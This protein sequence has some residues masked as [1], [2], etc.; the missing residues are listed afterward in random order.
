MEERIWFPASGLAKPKSSIAPACRHVSS[1]WLIVV[2]MREVPSPPSQLIDSVA[3]PV[4]LEVDTEGNGRFSRAALTDEHRQGL[5]ATVSGT[6]I[7]GRDCSRHARFNWGQVGVA[8]WPRRAGRLIGA[9]SLNEIGAVPRLTGTPP[10]ASR[11]P[12]SRSPSTRG[13]HECD[14]CQSRADGARQSVV[15]RRCRGTR[16]DDRRRHRAR[17]SRASRCRPES[18]WSEGAP[19]PSFIPLKIQYHQIQIVVPASLAPSQCVDTPSAGHP[20]VNLGGIEHLEYPEHVLGPHGFL[21]HPGPRPTQQRWEWRRSDGTP[22]CSGNCPRQ[23]TGP[24]Q[25]RDVAQGRTHETPPAQAATRGELEH[26]LSS[27]L[28]QPGAPAGIVT[29][30]RREHCRFGQLR[31]S[32][33]HGISTGWAMDPFAG[34]VTLSW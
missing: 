6:T 30:R 31:Q 1:R 8:A 12:L 5:S 23:S 34:L 15:P 27:R 7:S 21:M 32:S 4:S 10:R 9:H 25:R 29:L 2:V 33:A 17:T 22:A 14:L 3:R 26:V 13:P 24:Y 18:Q 19:C 20:V 28:S 11:S 16:C